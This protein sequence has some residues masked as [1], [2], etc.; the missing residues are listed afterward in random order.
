[1]FLAVRVS[2]SSSESELVPPSASNMSTGTRC[3][4]AA[5]CT[6]GVGETGGLSQSTK[7][8]LSNAP[9]Q[10]ERRSNAPLGDADSK[11]RNTPN[12]SSTHFVDEKP[13]K[14]SCNSWTTH[15]GTCVKCTSAKPTMRRRGHCMFAQLQSCNASATMG[16][17]CWESSASHHASHQTDISCKVD[18]T[19]DSSGCNKRAKRKGKAMVYPNP[20]SKRRPNNA[21][22]N[23]IA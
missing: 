20:A 8:L 2:K 7:T 23:E 21:M 3:T 6:A 22:T 11:R 19:T 9:T 4:L 12:T 10:R 18:L 16:T 1:M 5:F 13:P 14:P 15:F 17:P